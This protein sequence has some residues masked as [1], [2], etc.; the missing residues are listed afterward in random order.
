MIGINDHHGV[1]QPAHFTDPAERAEQFHALTLQ[2]QYL[3]L[4]EVA[5]IFLQPLFHL[6]QAVDGFGD[7][8]PVGQH[9]A[10]PA[11]VDVV[12]TT[13]Q[14]VLFNWALCLPLGADEQD[15]APAGRDFPQKR[16]GRVQHRHGLLQIDDVYA[17]TFAVDERGHPW[18][19]S[20]N[21]V[22]EVHASFQELAHREVRNG[23]SGAPLSG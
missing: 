14:G 7:R 4:W 9:A 16:Q 20:A 11:L 23:H 8:L 12:L 3:L 21:H 17:V 5:L 15:A 2:V 18:I 6:L 13:P 22:T 10:K 1:R 19:P